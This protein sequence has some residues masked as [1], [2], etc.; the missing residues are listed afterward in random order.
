M[1]AAGATSLAVGFADGFFGLI[2]NAS[3][4]AGKCVIPPILISTT[5]IHLHTS[6]VQLGG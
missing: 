2:L 5:D 3:R 6:M 1:F 4:R